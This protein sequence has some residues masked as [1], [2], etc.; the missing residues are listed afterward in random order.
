MDQH[1]ERATQPDDS[2]LRLAVQ[3]LRLR[4]RWWV[5]A[6]LLLIALPIAML[7]TAVGVMLYGATHSGTFTS[8]TVVRRPVG[9][10]RPFGWPLRLERRVN[11][12]LIGVDVTL[13]ERRQVEPFSRSDTLMLVSFDPS[14]NRISA[15]S[16]PRDTYTVIP[17]LGAEKINA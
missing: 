12:L 15:L 8:S 14:R 10:A 16:I 1:P 2:R 5:L 7:G 11:V 3:R 13:N 17:R 6:R 4:A 9:G